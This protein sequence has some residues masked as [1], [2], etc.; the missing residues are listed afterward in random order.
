MILPFILAPIFAVNI[1]SCDELFK[2]TKDS[3][4][5]SDSNGLQ[6]VI[7]ITNGTLVGGTLPTASTGTSIPKITSNQPS[8]SFNP[9]AQFQ[10]PIGYSATTNWKYVYISVQG[11]T[12]GYIKVTNPSTSSTSTGTIVIPITL[13]ELVKYGTFT[14]TYCIV[15]VNGL[16]SNW[17]TTQIV[18]RVP[19]TC[20]DA[21]M[22]G[23]EGLT[24]MTINLGSKAGTI[25]VNYDTFTVPDRIDIYQGT[26]WL[27]GTGTDTGLLVPPLCQCSNPLPGFVGK[28]G[29]LTFTY[30]PSYGQYITIYVSG[31]LGNSTAWNFSMVCAQ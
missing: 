14:I 2:T 31:C 25:N 11:A 6:D 29:I 18:L 16:V 4:V 5:T 1:I 30:N 13:P 27:T 20:A 12:N 24:A 23:N 9:G 21:K 8:V 28:V 7:V 26:R 3:I 22:S 10:L 17:V 15:D 19:L